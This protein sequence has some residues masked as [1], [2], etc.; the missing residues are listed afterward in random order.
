MVCGIR[1]KEKKKAAKWGWECR[2]SVAI[3]NSGAGK[4]A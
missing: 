3:L 1:A 2:G 4:E